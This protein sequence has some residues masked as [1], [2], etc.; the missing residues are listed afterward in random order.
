MATGR[1][2]RGLFA[3]IVIVAAGVVALPG[4]PSSAQPLPSVATTSSASAFDEHDVDAYVKLNGVNHATALQQLS[5]QEAVGHLNTAALGDTFAGMAINREGGFHLSVYATAPLP[6]AFT[7]E[8]K[9]AGLSKVTQFHQVPYSAR[10]LSSVQARLKASAF[11]RD[12]Q[13]HV[14]SMIDVQRNRVVLVA[15]AGALTRLSQLTLPAA[16]LQKVRIERPVSSPRGG[17]DSPT[18]GGGAGLS[19][20]ACT[21]GYTVRQTSTGTR[22]IST[23]GHCS[24]SLSYAGTPLTYKGQKYGGRDDFQWHTASGISWSNTVSDGVGDS[25]TPYYRYITARAA[26]TSIVTGNFYCK[27]GIITGYD[28]GN[29]TNVN[30]CPGYGGLSCT[31]FLVKGTADMSIPGDSGGPVYSSSTAVGTISGQYYGSGH[32]YSAIV[33][34][35]ATFADLGLEVAI[36]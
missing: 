9:A 13:G 30:F 17:V 26:T 32:P 1:K 27:T 3:G 10:E 29:V 31:F 25:S 20:T 28:C 2:R 35:Q 8:L 22:G 21:S 36:S 11:W 12:R 5:L 18:G 15:G 4:L 16:D 23:A 7:G 34:P 6:E 19:G 33:G 14:A 24:N